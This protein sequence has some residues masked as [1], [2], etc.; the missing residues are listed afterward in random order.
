M[1]LLYL[2]VY[3]GVG[4]TQIENHTEITAKNAVN[5]QKILK[6]MRR[7]LGYLNLLFKIFA[8]NYT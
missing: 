8:F 3:L 5:K 1:G 2:Y 6:F 7:I 4:I